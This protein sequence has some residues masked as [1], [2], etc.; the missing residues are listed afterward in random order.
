MQQ[1]TQSGRK[2]QPDKPQLG[3]SQGAADPP[4]AAG[5]TDTAFC[6]ECREN[7]PLSSSGGPL[8]CAKCNGQFVEVTTTPV[9][10]PMPER[11][12]PST[13]ETL[14][15]PRTVLPGKQKQKRKSTPREEHGKRTCQDMARQPSLGDFFSP[16]SK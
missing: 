14:P 9:R 7:V 1:F 10:T 4:S 11:R 2:S 5:H 12:T 8:T 6:H 13:L 15:T 3:Q 16:S